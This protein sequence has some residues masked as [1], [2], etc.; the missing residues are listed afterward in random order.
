MIKDIV[1]GFA[2]GI[3]KPLA[4]IFTKKMDTDLEKYKVNGQVDI[5]L[6]NNHL[7]LI[8]AQG[9]L[10]NDRMKHLGFRMCQYGLIAPVL[11]WL[12][13]IFFDSI[14]THSGWVQA[15]PK[16]LEYVPHT[17]VIFLLGNVAIRAFRK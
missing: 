11:V 8:K 17:V 15:L 6:M 12:N 3:F 9:S 10:V 5:A 1:A 13:C 16:N 14:V 4:S 7:E 2:E